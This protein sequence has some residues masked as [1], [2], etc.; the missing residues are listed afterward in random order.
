MTEKTRMNSKFTPGPWRRAKN[1][2][3]NGS[4]KPRGL[5]YSRIVDENNISVAYAYPRSSRQ[6]QTANAN[7]IAVAPEM[8]EFIN[9]FLTF[10]GQAVLR[11]LPYEIGK[12]IYDEA[13][14]IIK[15]AN[16][17]SESAQ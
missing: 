13:Q 8:Y 4:G 11:I 12:S 9:F 7:L 3:R 2:S 10:N 6:Y 15:K 17:E 16:G 1:L 14:N 5:S